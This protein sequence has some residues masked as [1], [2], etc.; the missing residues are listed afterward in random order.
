MRGQLAPYWLAI[1]DVLIDV[2]VHPDA[3]EIAW[4]DWIPET[5]LRSVLGQ[6]RF[7]PDSIEAFHRYAA[8]RQRAT[9]P[10]L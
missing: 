1:H 8:W 3:A 10:S 7:V 4:Y 5:E 2:E 6:W 9:G